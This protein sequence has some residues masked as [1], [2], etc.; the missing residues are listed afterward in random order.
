MKTGFKKLDKMLGGGINKGE[1]T[2]IAGRPSKYKKTLAFNIAYGFAKDFYKT[3]IFST[4]LSKKLIQERIDKICEN[5]DT[6]NAEE[7]NIEDY[8]G[9]NDCSYLTPKYIEEQYK[10]MS[11]KLNGV[12][13]II[14]D[15]FNDILCDDWSDLKQRNY[16]CEKINRSI[17]MNDLRKLAR[18]KD[19][20]IILCV[21][22]NKDIDTRKDNKPNLDDLAKIIDG[23]CFPDNVFFIFDENS[24]CKP[25]ECDF[26]NLKVEV[27]LNR[28]FKSGILN[29]K[30][31]VTNFK[32]LEDEKDLQH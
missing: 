3:M 7:F 25:E 2:I 12:N 16:N 5:G 4:N 6:N 19:I 29:F 30:L 10:N 9:I 15:C 23:E 14:I 20:A 32:L 8:I 28:N 21:N 1:V 31:N 26:K 27:S 22:L 13:A 18:D 17:V 24:C 11:K